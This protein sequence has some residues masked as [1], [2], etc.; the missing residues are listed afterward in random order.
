M[1]RYFFHFTDGTHWFTD[2]TGRELSGLRAARAYAIRHTRELK[3]AVCDPQILDMSC[4][5][6]TVV[7]PESAA[8]LPVS[9]TVM[10]QSEALIGVALFA[11]AT[12][13]AVTALLPPAPARWK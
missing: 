7:E 13:S 3:A 11:R 8:L 12:L 10:V 9:T 5:T 1:S 4:G 2:D 6:L